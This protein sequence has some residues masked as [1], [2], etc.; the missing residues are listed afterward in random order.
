MISTLQ[1]T[2]LQIFCELML[3]LKVINKCIIEADEDF[4]EMFGMS[5]LRWIMQPHHPTTPGNWV[6]VTPLATNLPVENW[7]LNLG[8][9]SQPGEILTHSLS[10][11]HEESIVCSVY[12]FENNLGIKWK[13]TKYL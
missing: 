13:F 2:L 5:G 9:R 7:D 10:T 4:K 12:T 11:F 6:P 8:L 3:N 1:K